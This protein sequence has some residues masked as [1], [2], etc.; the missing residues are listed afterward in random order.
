MTN[1]N[2]EKIIGWYEIATDHFFCVE[3]FLKLKNL[4]KKSYEAMVDFLKN[5][6]QKKKDYK[7]TYKPIQKEDLGE[8]V[9]TC[10][11]C[12]RD[13]G[14]GKEPNKEEEKVVKREIQETKCTCSACGNVWFY[15][16]EDVA[17]ERE[18][19][20]D[21]AGRAMAC[22]GGCL[23]PMLLTPHR[24]PIDLDKCPKCNSKAITKET[25]VHN[26]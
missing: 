19:I 13:Y 8:D 16:K 17:K 23:L 20:R 22:C 7:L 1:N 26:V 12:G 4:N 21:N 3:C 5:R 11:K 2:T 18:K 25:V 10:D 24:E 6:I 15:G 9:Y 14:R